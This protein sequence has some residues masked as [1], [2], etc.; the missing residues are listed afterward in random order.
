MNRRKAVAVLSFTPLISAQAKDSS[1]RKKFIGVWKLVSC[2][3]KNKTSGEV[4]YPFGRN[5]VGRIT[6][7]QAGR[8]SAL[9]MNPGRLADASCDEIR[10]MVTGFTAY[11]RTFEI[12]ESA[13]TVIHH[14]RASLIPSWVGTDL[15]R[16]YEFSSASQLV[17]TAATD[18]GT[19][20]LVWQRDDA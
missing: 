14:V 15:R 20:R 9:L 18:L 10:E 17:L 7:D 12:D 8:M 3:S 5:P 6:Y 2:E 11:L 13:R 16:T 19:T 4:R 1:V